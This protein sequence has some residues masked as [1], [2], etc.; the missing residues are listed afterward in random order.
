MTF[1]Q[2]LLSQTKA[3]TSS[4]LFYSIEPTQTCAT[5]GR[6][7]LVTNKDFVKEAEN[8]IDLAL[9]SLNN[10][11]TNRAKVQLDNAPIARTNRIATSNRFQE[12]AAK[13]RDMIP[14]SIDL[15]IPTNIAW[16]R[17]TPTA[18]NLTDEN[19]PPLAT[20]KKAKTGTNPDQ[21]TA[22][23]NDLT[24]SLA[25]VDLDKIEQRQN[26]LTE[27]FKVEI[28]VLCQENETMQ[29]TLQTQFQT[30]MQALEIRIEQCTH[31]FVTSMSQTLNKAVDHMNAQMA[32]S[33]DRLNDFLVSFQTQADRLTTQVD[34]IIN[35]PNT[36]IMETSPEGTPLHRTKARLCETV[37]DTWD[38][39]DESADVSRNSHASRASHP[40]FGMEA[41]AGDRK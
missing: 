28:A 17:R 25:D 27:T 32:R 11:T 10:H 31:C 20:P 24:D 35:S 4:N 19:F 14:T 12:Y 2:A 18:M 36:D 3:G 6:Y 8:F 22:I 1:K 7:L 21:E 5:M 34:R 26:E 37:P 30:T 38:M 41:T 16:K 29:K 15:P 9:A 33:D 39:D 13:L 23:M 40:T